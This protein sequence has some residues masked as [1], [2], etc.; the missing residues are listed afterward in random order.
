MVTS[1]RVV[2]FLLVAVLGLAACATTAT[3]ATV[4]TSAKV[5]A[6]SNPQSG[7][8]VQAAALEAVRAYL[9]TFHLDDRALAAGFTIPWTVTTPDEVFYVGMARATG[10]IGPQGHQ[11][12]EVNALAE[13]GRSAQ[14]TNVHHAFLEIGSP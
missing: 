13:N 7:D 11:I 5:G 9:G 2:R 14:L 4:P 10:R 1:S 6:P 3:P 12:F 8:R